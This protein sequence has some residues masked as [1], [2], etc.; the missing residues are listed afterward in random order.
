M[1]H[2]TLQHDSHTFLWN[3]RNYPPNHAASHP[4]RLE[5][6]FTLLW[7]SHNL[8][9][10]TVHF[11]GYNCSVVEFNCQIWNQIGF[12]NFV[13]SFLVA[14]LVCCVC[15]C[16]S[17]FD[18]CTGFHVRGAFSLLCMCCVNTGYSRWGGEQ[19]VLAVACGWWRRSDAAANMT[20]KRQVTGHDA[21]SHF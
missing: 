21:C 6:S 2:L 1:V 13:L 18:T 10:I 9:I 16:Q 15:L 5:F 12:M 14:Y 7:K 19:C 3:V 17:L 8:Q 4:G 20:E 11:L